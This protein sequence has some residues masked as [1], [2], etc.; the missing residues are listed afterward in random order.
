MSGSTILIVE[1]EA[2]IREIIK[3][4]IEKSGYRSLEAEDGMEAC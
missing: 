3:N 4:Y 1:D 2:P